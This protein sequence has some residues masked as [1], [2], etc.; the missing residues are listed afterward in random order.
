MA[1]NLEQVDTGER[2]RAVRRTTIWLSVLALAFY[3]GFILLSI[4]RAG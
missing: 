2:Q 3:G 1:T 4:V